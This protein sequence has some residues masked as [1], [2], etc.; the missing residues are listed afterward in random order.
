MIE[1]IQLIGRE[2][3]RA[4]INEQ[5]TYGVV[6]TG[7]GAMLRNLV[8]LAQEKFNLP[9]RIGQHKNFSGAVDI[10]STADFTA[11]IGLTQWNSVT[12]DMVM[13][14]MTVTPIGK[15]VTNIKDWVRGLFT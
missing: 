15:A 12:R 9:V 11:A 6:L 2:I 14:D 10:A 13:K 1:L 5:L 3:S 7:G 4:G 8:P